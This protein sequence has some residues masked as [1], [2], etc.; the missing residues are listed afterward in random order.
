MNLFFWLIYSVFNK[1]FISMRFVVITKLNLQTHF[2][3]RTMNRAVP[4][5]CDFVGKDG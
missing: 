1:Q 3:R 2:K 4:S 5:R